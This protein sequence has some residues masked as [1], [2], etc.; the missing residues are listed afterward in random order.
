MSKIVGRLRS[1]VQAVLLNQNRTGR[2]KRY[3]L[4]EIKENLKN[5]AVKAAQSIEYQLAKT[6]RRV[7]LKSGYNGRRV[8]R[9]P[10]ISDADRANLK[11]RNILSGMLKCYL[12]MRQRLTYPSLMDMLKF[13]GSQTPSLTKKMCNLQLSIMDSRFYYGIMYRWLR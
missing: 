13:G 4:N 3:V 2:D 10:H 11:V 7:L 12:Q 6:A 5:N 1:S 8:R 9:K